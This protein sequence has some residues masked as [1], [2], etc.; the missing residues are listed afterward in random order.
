MIVAKY[1]SSSVSSSP[2]LIFKEEDTLKEIEVVLAI[3]NSS[4]VRGLRP[5][6]AEVTFCLK[7]P[8]SL[9]RISIPS[10]NTFSLIVSVSAIKALSKDFLG[11]P[12]FFFQYFE[13][14][15]F[16]HNNFFRGH[17][18]HCYRLV[19]KRDRKLAEKI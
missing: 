9:I 13:Q 18:Y 19:L 11:N 1:Y 6:R 17:F 16:A 5:L 7:V 3:C 2:S 4:P 14:L 15:C 12:V 10:C 8:K